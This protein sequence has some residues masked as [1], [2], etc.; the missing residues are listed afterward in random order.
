MEKR[1]QCILGSGQETYR[2][3]TETY[4]TTQ[5]GDTKQTLYLPVNN[6]QPASFEQP[7]LHS[8]QIGDLCTIMHKQNDITAAF[9]QQQRLL[10]LPSRDIL[11]FNGDPL[12]YRNFIRAF[13]HGVESK[14][15]KV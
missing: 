5:Y 3:T 7:H 4:G 12:Q 2:K 13:E 15:L 10:S 6:E 1:Q 9:V 8:A 14:A 11:V